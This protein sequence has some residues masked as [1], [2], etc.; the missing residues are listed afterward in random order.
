MKDLGN[1]ISK[2]GSVTYKHLRVPGVGSL[3]CT[4]CISMFSGG[5]IHLSLIDLVLGR[6]HGHW[7]KITIYRYIC[8][9]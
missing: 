5:S 2:E 4:G 1:W 6:E 9:D 7:A 8:T 3:G